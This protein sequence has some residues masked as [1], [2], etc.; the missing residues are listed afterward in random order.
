M[1]TP[2]SEE[3]LNVSD[4]DFEELRPP[5]HDLD[6]IDDAACNECDG[7]DGATSRAVCLPFTRIH[8]GG[9]GMLE[10]NDSFLIPGCCIE[11]K[12]T[13]FDRDHTSA[14][15]IY[16][17]VYVIE[18][19]HGEFQWT[20]R[21]RYK[22][23][24]Q[25][26]QQLQLYR[27]SM[28][29]PLPTKRHRE[30][31]R[32][33]KEEK[34]KSRPLPRFPKKPESLLS[35]EEVKQRAQ[36]LE[37]YLQNLL[38]VP[39]YRSHPD[40]MQFLEISPFSFIG[41]LGAKGKEGIVNKRAGGH[42]GARCCFKIQFL[43]YQCCSRWRKRWLIVKD[44]CVIYVRPR[45]GAIKCVMLMDQ[46]FQ[47]QSGFMATGVN[48]GM[49]ISNLTRN[50]LVRCWTR[51]KEREWKEQLMHLAKTAG[52]DF[53]QPNRFDSFVPVRS[54]NRCRWFTD[55]AKYF[56]AV[57][58]AIEMA[59]EEIFI[60]DWWL[61][62]EIFLKRPVVM[63]HKWRLDKLLK[64]KAEE[65]V[66]VFVLLYKEVEMALNINSLYSKQRLVAQH[67]NI[68]VFRHP[69]HV[70]GGILL[71]A[72]HEKVVV[73]DQTYAF[74]GGLDLCYG[75]WDDYIHRL[76][77]VGGITVQQSTD[78]T[79]SETFTKEYATT[80]LATKKLRYAPDPS[81]EDSTPEKTPFA[82]ESETDSKPRRESQSDDKLYFDQEAGKF[83]SGEE[84]RSRLAVNVQKARR[85]FRAVSAYQRLLRHGQAYQ[86]RLRDE[87]FA[88]TSR[89]RSFDSL[90]LADMSEVPGSDLKPCL[91]D[92]EL[93]GLQGSAKLWLGKDYVNFI[94]KDLTDLHHP[95]VDIV[96]RNKTPRMP[97]HDI[98]AMVCGAA[99]R[100]VARHFIQRWNFT[101][102]EKAKKH[103]SY[104]WLLPKAYDD[105]DLIP[106]MPESAVGTLYTAD[107]QILRSASNWSTGIRAVESSIQSAYI[108][109]IINAKHFIYIENQFFITLE[110]GNVS[111]ENQ[112]GEALYVRILKAHRHKENLKVYVVMP[113][114]PAFEGEVGTDTGTAIQAVTHWN[115]ASMCRGSSSIVERLKAADVSDPY[116]YI[117]FFGLRRHD[118]LHGRLVQELVYVHSKLMIVDDEIA[119]IGS[120]NINDRSMLGRRDSELAVIV[121]DI[122]R[123]KSIM[124]GRIFSSGK[125]A[126]SLRRTL[127]RE[128]LGLLETE[129][130]DI[131]LRDPVAT[132][133]YEGVWKKTATKNTEIFEKVFRCIPSDQVRSF[134]E[135]QEFSAI[136]GLAETD[137]ESA[138]AELLELRGHLVEMPKNFLV[139]EVLT[140]ASGTKEA[141]MPVSL[142]T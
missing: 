27:A 19:R 123:E 32:S 39:S 17:N 4:L 96:N 54:A 6:A 48:H 43:F 139:D 107:C 124:D 79:D 87:T 137:P 106:P 25:L 101:K 10:P 114:L 85:V 133:F 127:F 130:S 74:L 16:P 89:S 72:H 100:D 103:E 108:D 29:I 92:E 86:E 93:S 31:R 66:R 55:G 9:V 83:V 80:V 2:P 141:L 62:P 30:R 28:A 65:G 1:E 78:S 18:L 24:Q 26:H 7:K 76:T 84:Q 91:E 63:G 53:T 14:H 77:D 118:E 22:H 67:P 68:K 36:Q 47:V 128:H 35:H 58:N 13:S 37:A 102:F 104:P 46:G 70:K 57:A 132:S 134:A 125:F 112:L 61:T 75:R 95:F 38:Q 45:D 11:L 8:D 81:A 82:G 73:V 64:R 69:D 3:N 97:W 49:L 116:Q 122:D 40:T 117:D 23:F 99:A 113:L 56:E 42:H 138:R 33:Y 115:Y 12:I 90:D 88:S 111:V 109:A 34:T 126:G 110:K 135:L 44:S 71:W 142:W 120:A 50:L 41:S 60:A 52:R 129:N 98:G 121:T 20:I 131:D 5:E 15:I 51:R 59:K 21:R 94:I 119:I 136:P 140:P 105:I